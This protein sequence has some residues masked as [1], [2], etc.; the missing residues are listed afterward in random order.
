M[1]WLLLQGLLK[2]SNP[3]G[4]MQSNL[5]SVSCPWTK[6]GLSLFVWNIT[7][8]FKWKHLS[9]NVLLFPWTL[10]PSCPFG[11]ALQAVFQ[12]KLGVTLKEAICFN[13]CDFMLKANGNCGSLLPINTQTLSWY[14]LRS[15][16]S[17]F[18]VSIRVEPLCS[19]L[20]VCSSHLG[21]IMVVCST[22]QNCEVF[23]RK[24]SLCF[25]SS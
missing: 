8:L 13:I 5:G 16:E 1:Y 19:L 20:P 15:L 23:L 6:G 25:V 11:M 21:V 18:G 2:K 7:W 22:G 3:P 9:P 24:T 17:W 10:L 14:E 12:T 4:G